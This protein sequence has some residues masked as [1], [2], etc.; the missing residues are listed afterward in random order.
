MKRAIIVKF[1][2]RH[3]AFSD[4]IPFCAEGKPFTLVD[5]GCADGGT[6]RAIIRKCIG[7]CLSGVLQ[8]QCDNGVD[9]SI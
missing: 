6:S 2:L 7:A 1:Y 3:F 8:M 4:E 9:L 5:Y